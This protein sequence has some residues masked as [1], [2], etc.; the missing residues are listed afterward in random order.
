MCTALCFCGNEIRRKD[1]ARGPLAKKCCECRKQRPASLS[2]PRF[3]IQ[4]GAQVFRHPQV[5]RGG[6]Y[7][8]RCDHCRI[9]RGQRIEINANKA[10]PR[11]IKT[12][13]V[14]E[15]EYVAASQHQKACS[16]SC[17]KTYRNREYGPHHAAC[18]F[19]GKNFRSHR[20]DQKY[21]SHDCSHLADRSRQSLK[22]HQCGK[23]FEEKSCRAKTR[24]Y[25]SWACWQESHGASRCQ[26]QQCGKEFKRKAYKHAWQGKNKF[27]SRECA[28]DHRWGADR[29]RKTTSEKAKRSWAQKARATT[30]KHK[31]RHYG[32][33]FDPACTREA[34]CE[35]DGWVC[36]Q[37]G[38][39]CNKGEYLFIPGTR[40]LDPKNAE[41]DHIWPLSMPG[42]PG[43]VLSNAQCLCRKCNGKKRAKGGSQL[44]LAYAG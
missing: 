21:C 29:P 18:I 42:G 31:C 16:D 2:G 8:K 1:G 34:V 25:C 3:C 40:R 20:S 37:C 19:C 35:R 14:C 43:N 38:I 44:R 30:L 7:P 13:V 32:C 27:C 11:S 28:W 33:H 23:Q 15:C 26:C 24:R 22:C 12:C 6:A 36:Q 17:K 41:H 5:K 4:C 10:K 39:Q 9:N